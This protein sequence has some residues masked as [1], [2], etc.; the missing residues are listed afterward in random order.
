[1]RII[2]FINK[3]LYPTRYSSD[4]YIKHMKKIGVKIGEGCY[5]FEPKSVNIDLYRPYL[6]K[7]VK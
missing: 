7:I 4:A 3:I 1:M 5:I 2:N 6:L